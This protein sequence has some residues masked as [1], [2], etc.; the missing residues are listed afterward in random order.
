[1]LNRLLFI[2]ILSLASLASLAN[3]ADDAGDDVTRA[4]ADSI[5]NAALDPDFIMVSLLCVS[6]GD[7]VYTSAGHSALRLQSPSNGLD[8]VYTFEMKLNA[9]EI[10]KFFLGKAMAGFV[11]APTQEF[12][13]IY[14]EQG[15]GVEEIK[16]NLRPKEEQRLWQFLD[17]QLMAGP[18]WKFLFMQNGCSAMTMYAIEECLDKGSEIRYPELSAHMNG[19]SYRQVIYSI[20]PDSPWSWHFWNFSM[21]TRGDESYDFRSRFYPRALMTEWQKAVIVDADGM[22]RPMA[23]DNVVCLQK[24]VPQPAQLV[25]PV[26]LFLFLLFAAVG[27]SLAER[28]AKQ[29]RVLRVSAFAFDM[30]LFAIHTVGMVWMMEMLCFSEQPG[31]E[32]NWLVV[33][34]NPLPQLAWLVLHRRRSYRSVRVLMAVVCV[35]FVCATP[36]VPP[37]QYNALPLLILAFAARLFP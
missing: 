16:L 15:R 22:Q 31:S 28:F 9:D 37:L 19:T 11:P 33:I 18:Q 20:F 34:F 36:I 5:N 2:F 17:E 32:W 26:A 13:D 29:V 4:K 23:L 35:L 25:T 30:V 10:M 14:K 12:L 3:T 24:A 21:G 27:I 8:I 6:P 7:L 1:M